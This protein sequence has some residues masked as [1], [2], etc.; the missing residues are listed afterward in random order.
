M[1]DRAVG[2]DVGKPRF[3][4]TPLNRRDARSPDGADRG[5]AGA[6]L[7]V[8]VG[9]RRLAVGGAADEATAGVVG[10][11]GR[12]HRA[13]I[14]AAL[15]ANGLAQH[16]LVALREARRIGRLALHGARP[17]RTVG[18]DAVGAELGRNRRADDGEKVALRVARRDSRR[19]VGVEDGHGPSVWAVGGRRRV[20]EGI[21]AG[22][23][24]PERVVARLGR[25]KPD[26]RGK[27]RRPC[28]SL[29]A[30]AVVGVAGRKPRDV[31]E[32]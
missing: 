2:E 1:P 18:E 14:A 28:R 17:P 13:T 23:N 20:T 25:G 22:Q 19:G 7:V 27:V 12:Q 5:D 8:G 11:D 3:A 24:A 29:A 4:T 10:V 21:G 9:R 15:L 30:E 6:L 26:V 32:V 16:V 31:R